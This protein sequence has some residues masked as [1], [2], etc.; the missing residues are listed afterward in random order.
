MSAATIPEPPGANALLEPLSDVLVCP[1]CTAP[2]RTADTGHVL[3]CGAECGMQAACRDGVLDF[4]SPQSDDRGTLSGF[5]YQWQR[6]LTRGVGGHTVAYGNTLKGLEQR[7]PRWLDMPPA[8]LRGLRALDIGCGHGLYSLA[9]ANLGARTVGVDL[10]ESVYPL[11]RELYA[12][13]RKPALQYIRADVFTL[14]LAADAFDVVLSIG[15]VH[16]TPDPK[17]AILACARRVSPGG[18]LLLYVYEPWQVGHVTMRKLFPF[19]RWLP[20]PALHPVCRLLAVPVWLYLSANRRQFPS[21]SLYDDTVLGLFDAY[22]PRYVF[23]YPAKRV[24]AWLREAGFTVAER[25]DKCMY[26]GIR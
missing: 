9:L 14:P 26:L 17:R 6:V 25:I 3:V 24:I 18:R 19:P 10:S 1:R 2:L 21:R 7:I 15:V 4:V 13:P 23:T 22:S 5:G 20:N 16:H 8:H 11:A 12:L